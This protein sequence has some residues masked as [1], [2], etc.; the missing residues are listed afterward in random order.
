MRPSSWIP[1]LAWMAVIMILSS[2]SFRSQRTGGLL[3]GLL[4]VLPSWIVPAEGPSLHG[5]LRKAAHLVEYGILALLW[6]RALVRDRS[7]PTWA[8]A[9]GAFTICVMWAAL[10]ETH[11]SFV[12]DRTGSARDVAVDAAGSLAVL[13]V[14]RRT[15]L[16]TGRALIG[17]LLWAVVAA[18]AGTL[19]LNQMRGTS[20]GHWWVTVPAATALAGRWCWGRPRPRP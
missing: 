1:P 13:A 15:W 9:V 20:S 17:F 10:D 14:A 19:A 18:G 12:P 6:F 8:A 3:V 2:A 11:Q 7:R 16:D 5:V 4:A